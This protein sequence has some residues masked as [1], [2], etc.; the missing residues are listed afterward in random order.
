MVVRF[1][2]DGS[3]D[4]SFNRKGYKLLSI[5]P[6]SSTAGSVLQQ[7]D[8]KLIVTGSTEVTVG[9]RDLFATRLNADGGIDTTYGTDGSSVVSFGTAEELA[10]RAVLLAN[11]GLLLAGTT[12][13]TQTADFAVTRLTAN[14]AL[15]TT[16]GTQGKVTVDS[17]AAVDSLTTMIVQSDGRIVLGGVAGV[18]PL[19]QPFLAR[20]NANGTLDTTFNGQGRVLIPLAP[21]VVVEAGVSRV[22]QLADGRLMLGGFTLGSLTGSPPNVTTAATALLE[23]NGTIAQQIVALDVT[24]TPSGNSQIQDLLVEPNGRIVATGTSSRGPTAFVTRFTSFGVVDAAFGEGARRSSTAATR[25][26]HKITSGS[27]SHVRRTV[28]S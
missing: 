18:I 19:R 3:L 9:D 11:G 26:A 6:G 27:D 14:G 16:F 21:P 12:S 8:G 7:P 2:A 4:T 23:A 10:V 25:R 5:H 17:G 20:L 24:G 13:S 1:N 15:D 22:V 28:V